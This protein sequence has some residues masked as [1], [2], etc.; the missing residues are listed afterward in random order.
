MAALVILFLLFSIKVICVSSSSRLPPAQRNE[1]SDVGIKM[2]IIHRYYSSG[3]PFHNPN[4]TLLDRA[5]D[6]VRRSN[7][8]ADN[9]CRRRRRWFRTN[10]VITPI[11]PAHGDLLAVVDVGTPGVKSYALLDTGSDVP[12]FQC[13][14]CK[15]CYD[16][17]PDLYDPHKS[18]SYTLI[19][20]SE[21][22]CDNNPSIRCNSIDRVTCS[23]DVE[24]DDSSRSI[25]DL[26]TETFT[27]GDGTK[28]TNVIFGCGHQNTG[29]FFEEMSGS[30][31]IGP[32]SLSLPSQL[33][34]TRL[35]FCFPRVTEETVTSG[36]L[37]LG[38]PAIF[39]NPKIKLHPGRPELEEYYLLPLVGITVEFYGPVKFPR[40]LFEPKKDGSGG[41]LLDSGTYITR[42][43][44]E[45]YEGVIEAVAEAM[46]EEYPRVYEH[47]SQLELCYDGG[48]GKWKYFQNAVPEITFHFTGRDMVLKDYATFMEVNT[49]TWC[50]PI[51]MARNTSSFFGAFQMQGYAVGLDLAANEVSF[52]SAPPDCANN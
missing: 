13:L 48:K 45:A 30:I 31:G 32:T 18:Q 49:G 42:L 41:F 8:R 19:K 5:I 15:N 52:T 37:R 23:Y 16:Q 25:G 17:L 3:S 11:S 12:W 50:F 38:S 2:E 24:Y 46:G 27:F 43:F 10:D 26:A 36:Q 7:L 4:A 20:C 14:P 34:V 39:S 22:R 35:S 40:D 33:K 47:P 51:L 9:Y 44:R 6:M 28:A 21:V 1:N 29:T